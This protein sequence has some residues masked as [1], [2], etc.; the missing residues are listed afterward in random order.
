MDLINLNKDD[1]KLSVYLPSYTIL[2]LFKYR[3]KSNSKYKI[4]LKK[5][6]KTSQKAEF[7]HL[8]V[9][10]FLSLIFVVAMMAFFMPSVSLNE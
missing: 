6:K 8:I 1:E 5:E 4:Y 2:K 3:Y 9:K 10:P 7:M